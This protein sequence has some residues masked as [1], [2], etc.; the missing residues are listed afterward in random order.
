MSSQYDLAR[1][2]QNTLI[3]NKFIAIAVYLLN[4]IKLHITIDPYATIRQI[5]KS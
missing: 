5:Y 1:V 2:Y 4:T 3:G